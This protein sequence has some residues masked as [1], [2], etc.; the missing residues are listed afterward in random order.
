[1]K[2]L[3]ERI[4]SAVRDLKVPYRRLEWGEGDV[5]HVTNDVEFHVPGTQRK[6]WVP[7]EF[8]FGWNGNSIDLISIGLPYG[9]SSDKGMMTMEV[10][11]MSKRG[12]IFASFRGE[13]L[14]PLPGFNIWMDRPITGHYHP[15]S[16]HGLNTPDILSPEDIGL[17]LADKGDVRY[18]ILLLQSEDLAS[19]DVKIFKAEVVSKQEFAGGITPEDIILEE[20]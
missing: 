2:N 4:K 12:I 1:M 14:N 15:R 6:G 7:V 11:L 5:I 8:N 18:T 3:K 13:M 17:M 10:P 19:I 16:K 20:I 9:V